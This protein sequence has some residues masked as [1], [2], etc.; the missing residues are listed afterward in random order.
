VGVAEA[1]LGALAA[2]ALVAVG[3]AEAV[4]GALAAAALVAAGPAAV[5]RELKTRYFYRQS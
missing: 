5:G 1:V 4:L 2:A 3:V